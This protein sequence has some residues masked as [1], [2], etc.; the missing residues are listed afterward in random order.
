MKFFGEY[1]VWTFYLHEPYL[2]GPS[3][4]GVPDSPEFLETI[5]SICKK[6]GVL[7]RGLFANRIFSYY[8]NQEIITN[9]VK[10]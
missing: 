2:D 1:E 8:L 9:T 7:S 4:R 6:A 5:V 3:G 10:K